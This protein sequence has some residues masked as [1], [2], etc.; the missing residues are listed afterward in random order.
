MYIT[1]VNHILEYKNDAELNKDLTLA[2]KWVTFRL[3]KVLCSSIH[4]QM[5]I[6]TEL[7]RVFHC[8]CLDFPGILWEIK[9]SHN[10]RIPKSSSSSY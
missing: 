2:H 10:F 6:L 5:L 3:S 9:I 8:Y 4:Q 1:V 7:W